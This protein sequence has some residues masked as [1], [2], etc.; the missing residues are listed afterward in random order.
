M[1][2]PPQAYALPFSV[3]YASETAQEPP[4]SWRPHCLSVFKKSVIFSTTM[5]VNEIEPCV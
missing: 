3:L 2:A 5:M 1:I 4:P